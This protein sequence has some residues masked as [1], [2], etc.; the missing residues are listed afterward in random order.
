M[1]EIK[2]FTWF[3]HPEDSINILPVEARAYYFLLEAWDH[4]LPPGL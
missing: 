4:S 1:K 3:Y 2:S